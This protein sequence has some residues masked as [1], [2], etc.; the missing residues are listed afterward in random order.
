[1][2]ITYCRNQR[3]IKVVDTTQYRR[4][5]TTGEYRPTYLIRVSDWVKVPGKQAETGYCALSYVWEQSGDV[6]QKENGEY[7]CIDNGRHCIVEGY[8]M[9][10]D[11]LFPKIIRMLRREKRDSVTMT[12]TDAEEIKFEVKFIPSTRSKA[13]IKHVTYEELLQ[14]ICKDFEIEY[15]WYDKICIDQSDHE[16]KLQEIKQMHKIY[17]NACYTVAIVPEVHIYDPKDF[18][19]IDLVYDD[20]KASTKA[21]IDMVA[22][23]LW[24]KRSWTLE[25]TMSSK[26]ILVIGTDTHFWQHSFHTCDI[27]TSY[28]DFSIWM[29]DFANQQQGGGSVNQALRQAQF[30]TSSKEHDKIFSLANIFPDLFKSM[31]INYKID[32]KTTLNRFY[33]TI[34]THDLSI[35]CFGS[36]LFYNGWEISVNTMKNHNLPS[37]TG[38]SGLHH[39]KRVTTTTTWLQPQHSLCDDMLLHIST[40]YYK[41]L[42]VVPYDC[43]C[44]SP[45]SHD[46]LQWNQ[47]VDN[48]VERW[49]AKGLSITVEE[50]TALIDWAIKMRNISGHFATHY[51]KPQDAPAMQARPLSLTENC[52]ECIILPILL[53]CYSL[54]VGRIEKSPSLKHP[55]GYSHDYFLPVIKKYVDAANGTKERY[56]A[57]GIYYLG[58]TFHKEFISDDPDEILSSIFGD[59]HNE[60]KEFIIQ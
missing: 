29:L 10:K 23:S 48:F 59:V 26:R 4:N 39:Y 47:Q 12:P 53:K 45:L 41:T 42:S 14:Q 50:D 1:M 25:E 37:W 58:G 7:D 34:A 51:Y 57:I 6:V 19:T 16:I 11:G 18:D 17:S 36:N 9:G 43:G 55:T 52:D 49:E 35:L 44:F 32:I 40:K 13:T 22:K 21:W 38:V 3:S 54:L 60:A 15:L 31:E 33:R 8:D 27:P 5:P 24:W 30:R 28:N 2:Y 56:K 46:K 20:T